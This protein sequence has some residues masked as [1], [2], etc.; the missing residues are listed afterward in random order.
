MAAYLSLV[1]FTNVP[2]FLNHI[3][4]FNSAV[5]FD[6]I[7]VALIIPLVLLTSRQWITFLS[8]KYTWW[9]GALVLVYWANLWELS[10][11][12]DLVHDDE[13]IIQQNRS[14][15][16]LLIFF[17]AYASFVIRRDIFERFLQLSVFLCPA[18][19]IFEFFLPEFMNATEEY[20]VAGRADG[21]FLNAN[22][23]AEAMIIALVLSFRQF[24]P[25]MLMLAY[26]FVGCGVI[27]TFS[28]NG[29]GAMVLLGGYFLF[30]RFLPTWFLIV[31]VAIVL[32]Y[33]VLI[34]YAEDFLYSQLENQGQVDNLVDRLSVFDQA[35][36]NTL[37]D[38]S[39]VGR[40]EVARDTL[41]AILE[42][43]INGYVHGVAE[44]Y[45]IASHNQ[46]LETWY[47]YGI[48]GLLLWVSMLLILNHSSKNKILGLVGIEA[49]LFLWFSLFN[50]TLFESNFWMLFYGISLCGVYRQMENKRKHKRRR[51]RRGSN[52]HI[53]RTSHTSTSAHRSAQP[54]IG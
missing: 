36:S 12:D 45:E 22:V 27:L 44:W 48:F 30:K 17:Y 20:L 8:L 37:D 52:P 15:R 50:H 26:L 35:T 33:S 4:S 28:R 6:L 19:V 39:A 51:R 34:F 23:A 42:H 53:S 3:G 16:A 10:T 46:A 29:I 41:D 13:S 47:T 38:G 21:M 5:V 32:S 18:F 49:I 14:Q 24:R 9:I 25:H 2:Q 1:M 31:P 43:P 40:L 11:I 7:L 54:N